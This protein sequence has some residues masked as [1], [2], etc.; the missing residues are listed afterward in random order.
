MEGFPT[1]RFVTAPTLA[2]DYLSLRKTSDGSFPKRFS[3]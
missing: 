2:C 1:P 3:N